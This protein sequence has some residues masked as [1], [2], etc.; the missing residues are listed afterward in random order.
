VRYGDQKA[1]ITIDDLLIIEGSLSPRVRGLVT[2]WAALHH[3][4]LREEWALAM[5]H[6]P[7]K[8]IPPLE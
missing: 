5:Q 8:A 7:L 1:V 6:A 2:E 4:E 3:D